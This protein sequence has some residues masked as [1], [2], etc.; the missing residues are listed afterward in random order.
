MSDVIV[1]ESIYLRKYL[2]HTSTH[3]QNPK[4]GNTSTK[5]S[6]S[7]RTMTLHR[8]LISF[9]LLIGT[10]QAFFLRPQYAQRRWN[11][12]YGKRLEQ[13]FSSLFSAS[14]KELD[15]LIAEKNQAVAAEDYLRAAELK[16]KIEKIKEQQT[17]EGLI[18]YLD[19]TI[20]LHS[21]DFR[22]P[23]MVEVPCS[24]VGTRLTKLVKPPDADTLWQWYETLGMMEGDP[25]WAELWPSACSLASALVDRSA[26]IQNKQVVELGSGLGVAGLTAACLGAKSVLLMDREPFALHCAMS[27]A[28][29]HGLSAA[30]SATEN[31][32]VSSSLGVVS[33]AVVD[34]SAP[35]FLTKYDSSADVIIASDVL[36][37]EKT[38]VALAKLVAAMVRKEGILWL[39]DPSVERVAG[40]RQKFCEA[41]QAEGAATFVDIIPLPPARAYASC[42]SDTSK[43]EETVLIQARWK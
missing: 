13:A 42:Y 3:T 16:S 25:S 39:T 38:V 5:Y 34:W 21:G 11:F 15:A 18:L 36:Y 24:L 41:L 8:L 19:Q 20:P 32:S 29:L 37:D 43:P 27:T 17:S 2:L 22:F 35:D 4:T 6:L 23:P 26:Q 33:A 28:A 30:A 31:S 12:S 40:V 14:T 1:S 9:L 10:M 7:N